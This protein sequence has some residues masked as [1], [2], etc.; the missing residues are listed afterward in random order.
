MESHSRRPF[1]MGGLYSRTEISSKRLASP[2]SCR[3]SFLFH[4]K[5][6]VRTSVSQA[7]FFPSNSLLIPSKKSI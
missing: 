2:D 4:T 7:Q 3:N 6:T 5:M 1:I